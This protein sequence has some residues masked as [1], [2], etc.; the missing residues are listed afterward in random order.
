MVAEQTVY[1]ETFARR[2][3]V[4]DQITEILGGVSLAAATGGTGPKS[5]VD[6]L[7]FERSGQVDTFSA[8]PVD[9]E[10]LASAELA[11]SDLTLSIGYSAARTASDLRAALNTSNQPSQ[12]AYGAYP[13]GQVG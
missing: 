12:T 10:L 11:P 3:R 2:P 4:I 7:A 13:Q 1:Y 9:T 6:A 5:M 8:T